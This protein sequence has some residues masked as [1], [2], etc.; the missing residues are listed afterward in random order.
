MKKW[1]IGLTIVTLAW[2]LLPVMFA[3]I[4]WVYF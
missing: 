4:W 2:L 1:L 3:V